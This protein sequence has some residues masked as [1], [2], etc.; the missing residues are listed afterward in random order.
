MA[1]V[2][3]FDAGIPRNGTLSRASLARGL[4]LAGEHGGG[5]G[6]ALPPGD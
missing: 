1:A 4:C 6:A 2:V 3:P 5:C